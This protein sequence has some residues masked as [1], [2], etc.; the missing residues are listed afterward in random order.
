VAGFFLLAMAATW[1]LQ[2]WRVSHVAATAQEQQETVVAEVL[3]DIE[4]Q[5]NDIQRELLARAQ[6]LAED[7]VVVRALRT[8][9]L[10]NATQGTHTLIRF[11]ADL[12]L[13]DRTAVELYDP[14]Q[15]LVVWNGFSLPLDEAPQ[16]PR[17]TET[18]QTAIAEDADWRQGL[19]VWYPV[20]DGVRVLGAVRVVEL[21]YARTPIRNQYLR[22]YRLGDTWQRQTGL[23]VS[24]MFEQPL[25]EEMPV[26]GQARYLQG[27]DG[28]ILGRVTVT[29][30]TPERLVE[31]TR[32]RYGDVLAFWTTLLMGWLM[33]GLWSWYRAADQKTKKRGSLHA[34]GRFAVVALAWWGLR[35]ALLALNVPARWQTG[36]APLSPLFD[37]AH[38]ASTLGNGL[39][40]STGDFFL[41]ALFTLLFAF[42]FLGFAARFR[43]AS[44]SIAAGGQRAAVQRWRPA[45]QVR[46]F[47]G[48]AVGVV[49]A[50]GLIL[51]LAIITR[52]AVLDSTLDFFSR[53]GLFPKSLV[54][55]IFCTLLLLTLAVM[56]LLTGLTWM[57]MRPAPQISTRQEGGWRV[58]LG[59]LLAAALPLVGI[60]GLFEVQPVVPW[61]M[62]LSFLVVGLGAGVWFFLRAGNYLDLF[63]LRSILT[64]ILLTSL[65]LY[66]LFY[67]GL[68]TQ[69]RQRMQ[70]A[71]ESF[72]E[73]RDPKVMFALQQVLQAAQQDP[74]VAPA[75]ADTARFERQHSYLD[76]LATVLLRGSLLASLGAYDVSLLFIDERDQPVGRYD[77]AGQS[78]DRTTLNQINDERF[79]ILQQM[80]AER[81]TGGVMVEQMTGRLASDRFQYAGVV[82]I[83][84]P[85]QARPVGWVMARAEQHSLSQE[86]STPFLRV[87]LPTG[88][89]DLYANLSLAE[90]REGVL[91]R[92]SGRDFGRYRLDESVQR[93][94][95]TAPEVWHTEVV[96][97][98]PFVTYYRR[99]RAE[100]ASTLVL[101]PVEQK[102]VAVRVPAINTFDHLYYLLR[103]TVAGLFI[104][105][106]C[107]G[108]GLYLRRRAG[109]LP[110]P[111]IR[112]RDKVLNAF[113]VVGIIAVTSVGF[114]GISVVT[115]ENERAVQSWLRQHLERVEETLALEAQGD[116][117]PYRTLERVRIDSLAARVGLDLNIYDS[118][119][120][121]RTSRPQLQR[122]R[123]ID[124]RLP[125]PAY[126]ALY[127]DGYQF[128]YVEEELGTFT[129][130]AGYRALLDEQGRPAYVV[131]VPTLPEQERI[132]EERARTV[133]YLFGALLL[134]VVV[135]MVTASLIANA[136]ARPIA[137]LR[138]G[139]EDVAQGRFERKLPVDTRDEVGELVQ[140][141]NGMQEQ[142][143]ESRR[144]LAQ[145]ERQLAW[146]E[147]ARQ[148]AHEIKNPLTPMK[149]SVQ[150]LRRAY[151][152]EEE[153]ST[154]PEDS[155]GRFSRLFESVT[156][157]LVEQIDTLAR[158][159]NEFST[160]ARMP[161]RVLERLDLNE[162]VREAVALMQA[163]ADTEIELHLA[164]EPLILEADHEEL[165]RVYINIIKNA[166]QALPDES[167]RI[168]V[169][170]EQ[171]E[172][173]EAGFA[174]S[175]V[176]DT[177]TGI[178]VDLRDKIFEPNFSTKTSGTGL[179]LAIVRKSIEERGGEIGFETE[180][181]EGTTFWIRLPL[182]V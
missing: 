108:L 35:Y 27:L 109:R 149:L 18:V 64:A 15:Q 168:T 128:T 117:M 30:P 4:R 156:G 179:G 2:T 72:V 157:T 52:Q 162:I 113:L 12:D 130:T 114:V 82:Q 94:L 155:N 93:D 126:Q 152:D 92:S 84:A 21:V 147:M 181:G 5:F 16:R 13:P 70:D 33:A 81:G 122:E 169:A 47:I 28:T 143:A 148:V 118:G 37:P 83:D 151:Q 90:F 96:K 54:L 182:V 145:Q 131:S 106:V 116:E 57:V 19:V 144:Q 99:D 141:F 69:R 22:N 26:E 112:F 91:L 97:E 178:P 174:Y 161:T 74:T 24:V 68:D 153:T 171:Q 76:S 110:A 71:A 39:M 125:I 8:R 85:D 177:G 163:E 87:L 25:P 40:R 63:T 160:F 129:Y 80:Y 36:K 127:L 136:L 164:A 7:P 75:L 165:R 154:Q 31:S 45:S 135:V 60:Y 105:V 41:T 67:G 166:L 89:S 86:G 62:T 139:L 104:G 167:G 3:V 44:P 175:T 138:V 34:G 56:V 77:A 6:A 48:V 65:L 137:R 124:T 66:P 100:P 101:S 29:P 88:Y 158:I 50:F 46:F 17:F 20:R 51:V 95:V 73:V 59:A 14:A 120:L 61:Q 115:G 98:R 173:G 172:G 123:L 10:G 11:F 119:R 32:T 103:L 133:A 1:G 38:L 49:L 170:T 121:V 142:L 146:R 78:F 55:L 140:T 102:I 43:K 180:E 134:L 107:Y 132:E 23:S 150:H 111:R 58:A 9:L 159:A 42:A 53:E 79:D 176:T